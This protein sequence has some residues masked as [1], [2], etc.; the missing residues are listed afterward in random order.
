MAILFLFSFRGHT[1]T[2][3]GEVRLRNPKSILSIKSLPRNLKKHI[4]FDNESNVYDF[5]RNDEK[6]KFVPQGYFAVVD[7]S[8][9]NNDYE[10]IGT[11]G[12]LPCLNVGVVSKSGKKI[13][14]G[15]FQASNID[16]KS[17]LALV[18]S[19][20]PEE[21]VSRVILSSYG[22]DYSLM[23]SVVRNLIENGLTDIRFIGSGSM[24]L[25]KYGSIYLNFL[26]PEKDDGSVKNSKIPSI[27]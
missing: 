7:F 15:H 23:D 21:Q 6:V 16:K 14:L 25:D 22:V 20:S 1:Q 17:I 5:T 10:F 9:P 3:I 26:V 2:L 8:S 24:F 11:G 13:A 27:Y 19:F 4:Q 18:N 12:A